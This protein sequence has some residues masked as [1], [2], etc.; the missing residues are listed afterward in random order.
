MHPNLLDQLL[1]FDT[2]AELGSF[3]A[4]SKKLNRTV[5][6]ITYTIG[7]L[8]GQLGLILFDRSGYRPVL[9]EEGQS[10]RRD[11]EIISRRIERLT[12]RADNLQRQISVN[13][14]LLVEP[15]F[16]RAPLA[17]A[18]A[19]FAT[20]HPEINLS[21]LETPNDCITTHLAEG[22]GDLALLA[23]TDMM[24]M[25][26][27]DGRQ[28]ALRTSLP[29]AAPDHPLAARAEPFA[30]QELDNH[31]QI[32][33]SAKS[34]DAHTY[35]YHVHVTDLWVASTVPMIHD[36]VREGVGWAYM[37]HDTVLDD[38]ASGRLVALKCAD[39]HDW[40]AMRYSGAWRANHPP[41]E[42]LAELMDLIEEAC[43]TGP[44]AT[45]LTIA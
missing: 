19:I 38:L 16:P 11:A 42:A 13:P 4:A 36:L 37:T 35:N 10:L 33:L 20:R 2:I 24:P 12:A 41:D 31:R 1:V 26:N 39:I 34:L 44:G 40:A 5:S 15:V 45:T 7:Q 8:E 3:S 27:F 43:E 14:T 21:I 28:I 23:L 22:K 30:L 25:R 6:A 17:K 18:L 29:V 9:T 32:I